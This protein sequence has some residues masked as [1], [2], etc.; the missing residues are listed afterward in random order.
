[1]R[2]LSSCFEPISAPLMHTCAS[3]IRFPHRGAPFLSHPARA[4]LPKTRGCPGRR[5]NT[6]RTPRCSRLPFGTQTAGIRAH[7]G[8]GFA[9][10]VGELRE[11][12]GAV[13]MVVLAFVFGESESRSIERLAFN[14]PRADTPVDVAR[15]HRGDVFGGFDAAG[16]S[17][18]WL[19][20]EPKYRSAARL[21]SAKVA[22]CTCPRRPRRSR[23]GSTAVVVFPMCG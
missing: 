18:H 16:S 1:M 19:I 11:A 21:A 5:S 20:A 4:L 12:E 9:C 7:H 15:K 2:R 8:H 23:G 3:L 17:R 10:A 6:L 14:R 22:T 13:F